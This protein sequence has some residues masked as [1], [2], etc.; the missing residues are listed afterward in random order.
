VICKYFQ[1]QNTIKFGTFTTE[2]GIQIQRYF[3]NDCKRKF[4]PNTLQSMQTPVDQ[5]SAAMGMYYRGMS[6]DG[7]Q[8]QLKDQFGNEVSESTIYYWIVRF[9]KDAIEKSKNF[10]PEVGDVWIAD[11]TGID[12][13]GSKRDLWFWDI[14]DAKTRYL[15]ASHISSTRTAEDAQALITKAIQRAGK[16]PRV[17]ITDKLHAYIAGVDFAVGHNNVAHVRSKPFTTIDSTNRIERFHGTFK[18][19]IKVV[20]AY[21]NLEAANLITQGWLIHYNFFKQHEALGNV[22]P[23]VGMGIALPFTSWTDVVT[24][25]GAATVSQISKPKPI[26]STITPEQL[27]KQQERLR[28]RVAVQKHAAKKKAKRIAKRASLTVAKK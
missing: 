11:E 1:S 24:M 23:A 15:L 25:H 2:D 26:L 19:R 21:K 8:G 6:L 4:V 22:P 13:H 27:I 5:V 20:R 16:Y 3:C 9:T 12:V 17:I 18:D 7:I 28:I 10:T 14:I